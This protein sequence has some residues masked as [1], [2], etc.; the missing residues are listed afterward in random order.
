MKCIICRGCPGSGKSTFAKKNFSCCILENDQF[1]TV[2]GEYKWSSDGTKRA[3]SLCMSLADQILASGADVCV[4]NTFTQVKFIEAYKRIA[5]RYGAKFEVYR[6]HG[7][8]QNMHNVP[9]RTL[10]NM[11]TSF[12]DWPGEI[13]VQPEI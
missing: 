5:D 6:L 3:I 8:F 4:C 12:Q 7:N 2:D 1:Q 9:E 13:D 11:K 10:N